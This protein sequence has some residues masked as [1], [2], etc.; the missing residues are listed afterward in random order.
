MQKA[1][2]LLSVL[3]FCVSANSSADEN[4]P[5]AAFAKSLTKAIRIISKKHFT[6]TSEAQL[7]DWSIR[8]LYENVKQPIPAAI[9]RRLEKLDKANADEV[10]RLILDARV[11]L[12]Q[13]KDLENGRDLEICVDA[14]FLKLEPG[15]QPDLRNGLIKIEERECRIGFLRFGDRGVGLKLESDPKTKML[16]VVTPIFKGPGYEAGIRAGDIITEIRLVVDRDGSPFLAPDNEGNLFPTSQVYSTKG[17][18]VERATDL[19][20]GKVGTRVIVLV[21]PA[22]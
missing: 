5:S 9:T 13:R 19:L 4:D 22:K 7:A 21:V 8:G 16:R 20:R 17:M 10:Q 12:G 6:P 1:I 18:T 15:A 3:G 11:A 2:L 14:I